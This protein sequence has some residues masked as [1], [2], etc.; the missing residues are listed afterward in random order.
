MRVAPQVAAAL[1]DIKGG[2]AGRMRALYAA[3]LGN[4]AEGDKL[5]PL[6]VAKKAYVLPHAQVGGWVVDGWVNGHRRGCA[7]QNRG[8]PATDPPCWC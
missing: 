8:A 6:L 4:A 2:P 5:A 3:V 1:A 7:A